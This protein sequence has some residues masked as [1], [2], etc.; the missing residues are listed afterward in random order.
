MVTRALD[1]GIL[2]FGR[3]ESGHYQ[4]SDEQEEVKSRKLLTKL[5]NAAAKVRV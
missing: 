3:N 1:C 4:L 5:A 2:P